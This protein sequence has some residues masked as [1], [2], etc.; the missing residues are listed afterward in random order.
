MKLSTWDDQ[1]VNNFSNINANYQDQIED[2]F[3]NNTNSNQ[4]MDGDFNYSHLGMNQNLNLSSFG[5]F[6]AGKYVSNRRVQ[7]LIVWPMIIWPLVVWIV[8][9]LN[10]W[11]LII[12]LLI[13]WLLIIWPWIVWVVWLLIFLPMIIRRLI[14]SRQKLLGSLASPPLCCCCLWKC[15]CH[16]L[17]CK[18][19]CHHHHHRLFGKQH[20]CNVDQ[21]RALQNVTNLFIVSLAVADLCVAGVVMPFYAYTMVSEDDDDGYVYDRLHIW[22]PIREDIF[23]RKNDF[24]LALQE[25]LCAHDDTFTKAPL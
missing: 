14:A 3:N 16:T 20:Q 11:P 2:M 24:K 8:W 4:K 6:L 18:G 12:W 23:V 21:E 22:I 7:L 9:L 5:S 1:V 13:V 25:L 19:H 17:R 15:P 10:V